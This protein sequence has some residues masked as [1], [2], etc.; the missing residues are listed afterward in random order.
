MKT[1]C[2]GTPSQIILLTRCKLRAH[3]LRLL[4]DTASLQLY[5]A[6][7][8]KS[9][10]VA[11]NHPRYF[12]S[13]SRKNQKISFLQ[14]RHT[15]QVVQ[16]CQQQYAQGLMPSQNRHRPVLQ[17]VWKL[18]TTSHRANKIQ[19]QRCVF[20]RMLAISAPGATSFWLSALSTTCSDSPLGSEPIVFSVANFT[21]LFSLCSF[22]KLH[23]STLLSRP[24]LER[25]HRRRRF[26]ER[27]HHV[28]E[29][30]FWQNREI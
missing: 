30:C 15:I 22:S 26:S 19:E 2:T 9:R 25:L 24:C 27:Y 28:R 14:I 21:D 13:P 20:A 5:L 17:L 10:D 8:N 4:Y 18:G 23:G 11:S 12:S 3:T 7:D 16:V 29:G 6:L 1:F